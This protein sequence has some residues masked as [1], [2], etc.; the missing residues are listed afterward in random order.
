[1][2][3][4]T[5]VTFTNYQKTR[6]GINQTLSLLDS[7]YNLWHSLSILN[8]IESLYEMGVEL[9]PSTQEGW[10]LKSAI[11]RKDAIALKILPTLLRFDKERLDALHEIATL[12]LPEMPMGAG[13]LPYYI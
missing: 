4:H 13:L 2:L 7:N 5:R 8:N 11:L 1:M 6:A 9:E 12:S 10:V 3:R